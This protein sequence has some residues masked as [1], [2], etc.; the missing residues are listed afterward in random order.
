VA[1]EAADS[2]CGAS[3]V[4]GGKLGEHLEKPV[5][6]GFQ[7]VP[8]GARPGQAW[9][10]RRALA[11]YAER[12]GYRLGKVFVHQ[13]GSGQRGELGALLK[14]A[15]DPKVTAVAVVSDADLSRSPRM[16]RLILQRLK[17]EA[18]VDVKVV[19]PSPILNGE[20]KLPVQEG[21]PE[22]EVDSTRV[23]IEVVTT[24]DRAAVV[25]LRI[26]ADTVEAWHLAR[27]ISVMERKRLQRWLSRP[28]GWFAEG[29]VVFSVDPRP[30]GD[31]VAIELPD[32]LRWTLSPAEQMALIERVIG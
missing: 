31:R 20:V 23:M 24:A 12:K 19:G 14:A 17:T 27:L 6:L 25:E 10:V 18:G 5:L 22:I 7:T 32:V 21:E 9:R 1:R 11:A 16:R 15:G 29:A 13:E 28:S 2:D 3:V 4:K 30:S 8:M 26:T